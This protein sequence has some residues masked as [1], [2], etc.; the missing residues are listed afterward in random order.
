MDS[1][2][3]PRITVWDVPDAIQPFRFQF[4]TCVEM[5]HVAER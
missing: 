4:V 5:G 1:M 2:E 3:S